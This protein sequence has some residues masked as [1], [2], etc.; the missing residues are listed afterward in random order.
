MTR[1]ESQIRELS[2]S[3]K[4]ALFRRLLFAEDLAWLRDEKKKDRVI[5]FE[6]EL[7]GQELSGFALIA[8][9]RHTV[10]AFVS[11]RDESPRLILFPTL[12]TL[13]D[14]GFEL[15]NLIV[16]R[17]E[18]KDATFHGISNGH[19]RFG[20]MVKDLTPPNRKVDIP[21][22]V[23]EQMAGSIAR[24]EAEQQ[25]EP[26]QSVSPA[27]SVPK[28]A[29]VKEP[30][31]PSYEEEP[32]EEEPYEEGPP[33]G[34]D[35]EPDNFEDFQEPGYDDY[36]DYSGYE[37][38]EPEL[39]PEPKKELSRSEKLKAQ[40]FG[41]LNEVIDFAVMKLGINRPLAVTLANKAMQSKVSPEY[42]V[43]LAVNI[44]CKLID[45][46]RI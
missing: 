12:E 21:D 43:Q 30:E 2:P 42:R 28:P 34:F 7:D 9:Q 19:G 29:P 40:T 44:F 26:I 46:N 17:K 33:E 22:T 45:E 32:Y 4:D 39:E 14:P 31:K 38:P 35:E 24:E 10:I 15:L 13:F 37:E 20:D 11:D 5:G 27:P 23:V 6:V 16:T 25:P 8:I 3:V 1:L 41:S 36:D 18:F